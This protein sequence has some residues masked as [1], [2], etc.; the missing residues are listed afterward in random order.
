MKNIF[1]I[2]I[3]DIKAIATHFFA[4]VII[5]AVLILPAL[6]AW[7]NIY[8]NWDPYGN[9]GNVPIALASA[10]LG[11]VLNSGERVNKGREIIEELAE[12]TSIKWIITD[13][14]EEAIE[15]VRRG[16]YYGALVMGENLSRNMYDLTTALQDQEPSI[17]FYQNAKTNAI[18]NKIT[19]TASSTAEHKIQVK[20]LS[21]LIQGMLENVEDLLGD[22]DSEEALDDLIRV[23]TRLRGNLYEYAGMIQNLRDRERDILA[24]LDSSGA[25]VSGVD[26][27]DTKATLVSAKSIVSNIEKEVV[28]RI[29]VV[30]KRMKALED[31][32]KAQ[33]PSALSDTILE[34]MIEDVQAIEAD[35][36]ALRS[37][38]PSDSVLGAAVYNS[39]TT[40]LQR[41]ESLEQA[42]KAQQGNTLSDQANKAFLASAAAMLGDAKKILTDNFTPAFKQFFD[43]MI[44]D[45]EILIKILDGV[46]TTV[47][48]VQPVLSAAKG[49][50]VAVNSTLA[51]LQTVL[52]GAAGALD[53]LLDKL[54]QARDSDLLGDL[55]ELLHGDPQ[56]FAEFFSQPV[57]VTTETIY[58]VANYGTAM[59]PFYTTL[60]IWVGAVVSGAI[61]K[62]EPDVSRLKKVKKGQIFWGRFLIF[63]LL[64]QIQ[65]AIIV[66]GDI[67]L[68]GCQCLHPGLFFLCGA[69]ASLVFNLL[70]YAL[71]ATFG[72]IGKAI[73]VVI[74]IVQIA[75][76]SGSYPIEI[77]PEIFS[78]IYTFFPFPYAINAMRETLCGLYRWDL[79]KYLG[80]LLLF[81]VLA[82][83][84]GLK[85]RGHFAGVNEFVEEEMRETGVL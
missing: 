47:K 2:F 41:M 39:A 73:G 19:A 10:D 15:G 3:S 5:G 4:M 23:L 57:E 83:L 30:E 7:V 74:M 13:T 29:G 61:I 36:E 26:V 43:N 35:L 17:V 70:M 9:T 56:Q 8:A 16:D 6:Y 33:D 62:P 40:L 53:Q 82:A 28:D 25:A 31:R 49:T 79:Y 11:Y 14:P 48:D 46:N 44:R 84:I 45:L 27:S 38:I 78:K 77:L 65:A 1:K 60:A 75:G 42:M 37:T 22:L 63:F 85:L 18:A 66:A 24:G 34:S 76:S 50:L 12:S 52:T 69:V 20:Y 58:P 32:V 54:I 21:V 81:G 59:T 64:G 55:I 67:Y 72:D 68:L 71:T 51:Q 80:E